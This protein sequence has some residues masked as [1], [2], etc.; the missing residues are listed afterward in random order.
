MVTQHPINECNFKQAQ[1]QCLSKCVIVLSTSP[2]GELKGFA[3]N[4]KVKGWRHKFLD[5]NNPN[6]KTR[7]LY[8]KKDTIWI[9]G[10]EIKFTY[11][12]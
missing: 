9:A 2:G 4:L 8:A 5:T 12:E 10:Y 3:D 7:S 6:P 1:N 11:R